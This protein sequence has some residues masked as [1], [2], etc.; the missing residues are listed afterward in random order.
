MIK[1]T[2]HF[3]GQLDMALADAPL[4]RLGGVRSGV[5]PVELQAGRMLAPA[6]PPDLL[7]DDTLVRLR[8]QLGPEVGVFFEHYS[9][10]DLSV[11]ATLVGASGRAALPRQPFLQIPAL[12]ADGGVACRLSGLGGIPEKPCR[13]LDHWTAWAG[14]SWRR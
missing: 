7:I 4:L 6:L 5:L 3:S 12:T 10:S 9:G 1:A 13:K 11:G 14:L 2:R 8:A